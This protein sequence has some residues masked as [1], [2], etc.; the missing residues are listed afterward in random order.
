MEDVLVSSIGN[1]LRPSLLFP[2]LY[3]ITGL[4]FIQSMS[5]RLIIR[6]KREIELRYILVLLRKPKPE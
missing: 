2:S 3:T 6:A 1:A 4:D 5:S